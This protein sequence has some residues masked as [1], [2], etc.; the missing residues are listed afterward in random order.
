MTPLRLCAALALAGASLGLASCETYDGYGYYGGYGRSYDYP[1]Y[2][3]Y[4]D[5]YYPGTGYYVYDRAG[6]HHRWTDQQRRYWQSRRHPESGQHEVR[7]NWREYRA[8]QEDHTRYR[9]QQRQNWEDFQAGRMTREQYRAE[10]R[11]DRREFRQER[12]EDR[13]QMRRRNWSDRKD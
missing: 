3:G 7:R 5:Y 1:Y 12:R 2:G 11:N 8:D 4:D 9:A 6:R 13:K 10:R